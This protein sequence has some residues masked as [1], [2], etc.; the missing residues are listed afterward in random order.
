MAMKH[1]KIGRYNP[2]AVISFR[3]MR[4]NPDSSNGA[5]GKGFTGFD[6]PAF[7][8]SYI[9]SFNSN[10]GSQ[11][12]L[13]RMD[14]IYTFKNT[15]REIQFTVDI[16]CEA[17]PEDG[18]YALE[19]IGA[20][21]RYSYPNYEESANKKGGRTQGILA[22]PPIIGIKFGNLIKDSLSGTHLP[23]ILQSV[24]FSPIA[25]ESRFWPAK[26]GD[27]SIAYVPKRIQLAIVF[28]PVHMH[29]L[30]YGA[31]GPRQGFEQ[32]P[33]GPK[34][35]SMFGTFNT[36][37]TPSTTTDDGSAKSKTTQ[38]VEKAATNPKK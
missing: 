7:L 38:K 36:R 11:D 17:K 37:I 25:G 3:D 19:A 12:V 26:S 8:V 5:F 27:S 15:Q 33:Y 23:G 24:A 1:S 9:D 32:F 30:G 31:N 14:P 20:L 21:V 4:D 16:P 13:G 10:W 6:L 2:A 28:K 35:G 34:A 18:E 22:A 29:S